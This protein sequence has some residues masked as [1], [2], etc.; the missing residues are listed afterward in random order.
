MKRVVW[1]VCARR[2]ALRGRGC[3]DVFL[4]GGHG[5]PT[6][7]H[8]FLLRPNEPSAALL[9]ADALVRL[10]ARAASRRHYDFQ[11]ATSQSFDDSSTLFSYSKLRI[12]AVAIAHQLPWMTGDPYALW[13]HVRGVGQREAVT[14]WSK[15][16]GFNM[17]WLN[18]DVPQQLPAPEGLV[19]WTPIEGATSYQVLYTDSP[20]P[21]CRSRRLRTSPTSAST[22]RSTRAWARP[23]HWRV[24]A[25][26]LHRRLG[27]AEE[28]PAARELR[29]VEPDVHHRQPAR[30]PRH[31]RS[32]RHHLGHLGQGGTAR[33]A[34]RVDAGL[35]VEPEPRGAR[36]RRLGRLEPV[37]RLHLHRQGLRE[38]GVRRLD[39]RL[40]GVRAAHASAA[41]LPCH[42]TR[43]RSPTGTARRTSRRRAARAN[44]FD[45]TGAPRALER[46]PGREHRREVE[47]PAPAPEPA[48]RPDTT[49]ASG[50]SRRGRR[51]RGKRR[52]LGL[53][54][55]ERP[56][57][58]DGRA[59]RRA[60]G[61]RP[62]TDRSAG[63]AD[64]V[65]GR[66]R[67]AGPVRSRATS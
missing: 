14:P 45:A 28:R 17:R 11:L 23:I 46:G 58:L 12:P 22:S 6:G 5:A 26:R 9:S 24:R 51:R 33:G 64:R 25:I 38:P 1:R 10:E 50:P 43:R 60:L 62:R 13:V 15:P 16:F 65:P 19:R 32:D 52:S 4:D 44:A 8:A 27:R 39:R 21:R 49:G 31:A 20:T 63:H 30:D 56:L 53:R 7:L 54:L 2:V 57:L 41:R 29:A 55:A 61:R 47:L 42:R 59:R 3:S 18:S 37:P 35:R 40:T 48:A 67:S 66:G 36:R 34:G